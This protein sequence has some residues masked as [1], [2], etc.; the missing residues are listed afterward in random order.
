MGTA[1]HWTV[2]RMPEQSARGCEAVHTRKEVKIKAPGTS[3]RTQ[4][5]CCSAKEVEETGLMINIVNPGAGG[6]TSGR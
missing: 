1:T 5:G 6:N 2:V 3:G 4:R